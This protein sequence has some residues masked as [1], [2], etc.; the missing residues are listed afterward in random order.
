M[1]CQEMTE[2]NPEKEGPSPQ[3]IPKE[4]KRHKWNYTQ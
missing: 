1:A 2:A 4:L 3:E